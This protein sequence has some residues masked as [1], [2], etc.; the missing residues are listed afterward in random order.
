MP[1][2]CLYT[3]RMSEN[4]LWVSFGHTDRIKRDVR[5]SVCVSVRQLK[6]CLDGV[7]TSTATPAP[8]T[9]PA[10]IVAL[11]PARAPLC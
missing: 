7:S 3:F 11:A 9:A 4:Y 8:A 2:V 5:L 10:T 6:T 1:R